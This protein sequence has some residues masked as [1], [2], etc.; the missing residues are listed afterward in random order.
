MSQ[1]NF[2]AG[3]CAEAREVVGT[4]ISKKEDFKSNLMPNLEIAT[5]IPQHQ[6]TNYHAGVQQ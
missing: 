1:A 6:Y 3:S 5:I 2:K 4:L